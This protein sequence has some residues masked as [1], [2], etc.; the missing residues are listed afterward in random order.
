MQNCAMQR[1]TARISL[2]TAPFEKQAAQNRE[3]LRKKQLRN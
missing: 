1:K 2:L 3:K